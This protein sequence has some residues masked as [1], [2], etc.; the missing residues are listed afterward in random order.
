MEVLENGRPHRVLLI[1]DD[2]AV[3]EL[4]R[5]CLVEANYHVLPSDHLL[6]PADV[7]Q[8][9]PDVI[10]LDLVLS[11][12]SVGWDYVRQLKSLSCTARLPILVCSGD[13]PFA[14]HSI[15]EEL[16]SIT[17]MLVKPLDVQHF[18]DSVESA[19]CHGHTMSVPAPAQRSTQQIGSSQRP[20]SRRR[21][22]HG[23]SANRTSAR[24]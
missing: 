8:L 7:L 24:G 3:G 21:S 5:E 17:G 18:L 16:A 13:Y 23:Q 12:K 20:D 6:H 1:E 2:D 14:D 10:L 11:G 9:R 19:I 15:V 4:M 22:H